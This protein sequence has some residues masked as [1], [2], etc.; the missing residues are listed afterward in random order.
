[1]RVYARKVRPA[2]RTRQVEL[3]ELNAVLN[4]NLSGIR[5]IKAFTRED[6]EAE[7][8]GG[9]IHHYRDSLLYALR[10]MATFHP[11]IEF[12]SALGMI[13]LIYFGGR[14]AFNQ[15]LPVEDLVAFFLY[16]EMLY[17]PVQAL[18]DAWEGVQESLAGAERVAE[19]LEEEPDV[20]E[21][22][23]AVALDGR[24]GGTW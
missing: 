11:I 22:P 4:D 12:T 6:L 3:G 17:Q 5:E 21:R 7:N 10:L 18:S 24:P 16:L 1:M 20:P 2:F 9:R 14:L 19:L 8:V 13:G 23:D 15:V